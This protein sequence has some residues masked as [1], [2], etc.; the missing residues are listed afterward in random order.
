MAF[1]F[2]LKSIDVNEPQDA[3]DASPIVFKLSGKVTAVS[4]Q[5]EKALSPIVS[6][7]SEKSTVVKEQS[8]KAASPISF[9][10]FGRVMLVKEEAIKACAP[11]ST[12]LSEKLIFDTELLKNKRAA[13]RVTFSPNTTSI[14]Q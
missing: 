6:N 11:I 12:I 7:F 14:L 10:A 5:L 8:K 13:T 9:K 1:K 2:S 4:E 3:K